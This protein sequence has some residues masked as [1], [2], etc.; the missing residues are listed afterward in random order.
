MSLTLKPRLHDTTG[1]Q[2][3]LTTGCIVQTNIQP[4]VNPV[5]KPVECLYTRYSR[6]SNWLSNGTD[7]R[8]DNRL[9]RTALFVQPVVKRVVQPVWQPCVERT[10][11]VQHG[12]QTG[13]TTVLTTGCIHDTAVCQTS[14]QTGLTTGW[15]F[16]YTMQPVVKLVWPP[17]WQPIVSEETLTHPPSWSSSNH[18]QLLPSTTIHSILKLCAWQSFC[19]TSPTHHPDHRPIIISFFH[20]P[21][22]IASSNYVLDNNFAQPLSMSSL[23]Y[24]LVWSPPPHIPYIS[25]PN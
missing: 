9:E 14:C 11:F 23:V 3:G 17:L 15:M 8:F 5:V 6:L 22:S 24:L 18:Y 19:T 20:L 16:V 21:W 2:S 1:C 4:V 12:C 13:C 25:S 10:L 7:N